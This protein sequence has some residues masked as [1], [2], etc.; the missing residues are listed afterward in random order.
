MLVLF[1]P[2]EINNLAT[3]IYIYILQI[4]RF[5][6]SRKEVHIVVQLF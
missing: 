3:E 2:F 6:F 5:Y 1:L 4:G